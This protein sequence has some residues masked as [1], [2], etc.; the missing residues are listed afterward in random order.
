M[1][2]QTA[3]EVCSNVIQHEGQRSQAY[4]KDKVEGMQAY[5]LE[6]DLASD[7]ICTAVSSHAQ[8]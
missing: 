1:H 3:L 8:W 4:A 5:D 2:K 6:Y 7:L